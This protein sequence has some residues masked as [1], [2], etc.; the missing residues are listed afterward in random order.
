MMHLAPEQLL[1]AVRIDLAD[2]VTGRDV[3]LVCDHIE[4]ALH[5]AK[6]MVTEVFLDPT[7]RYDAARD[8]V[9]QGRQ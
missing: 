5:D 3:E 9:R 4:R 1:V 8:R 7:P 6:P 2:D